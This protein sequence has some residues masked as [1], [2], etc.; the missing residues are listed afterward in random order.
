MTND[1]EMGSK[2]DFAAESSI[3]TTINDQPAPQA[4]DS[5]PEHKHHEPGAKWKANEVHTL[6]PKY[7][8]FSLRFGL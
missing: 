2:H 1:L 6:P 7:V 8:F 4:S 5:K 3:E